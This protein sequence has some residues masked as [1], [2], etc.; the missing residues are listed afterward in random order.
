MWNRL[1]RNIPKDWIQG[2]PNNTEC[3]MEMRTGHVMRVVGLDDPDALRGSGL[4]LFLGD[5]WDD[6]KPVILPE[7]HDGIA[8][9]CAFENFRYAE[10]SQQALQPLL[11]TVLQ[12]G[13]GSSLCN[14]RVKIG[15]APGRETLVGLG[16]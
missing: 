12:A 7:I 13:L 11:Q 10:S 8:T 3:V 4:W 16:R 9:L 1:K 2:R 6:A 5:E 15:A 14:A